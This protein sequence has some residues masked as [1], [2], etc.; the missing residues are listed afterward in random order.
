RAVGGSSRLG[1]PAHRPAGRARALRLLREA[2]RERRGT[3]PMS[4]TSALDVAVRVAQEAGAR[5]LQTFRDLDP[6]DA[7]EKSKTDVVSTADRASEAL[8]RKLLLS[9]FPGD[10]FLGEESGMC[11]PDETAPTWLVDPLD[12]TANFVRGFPHWAVS[13]ARTRGGVGGAL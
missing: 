8:C 10:S 3:R 9:A 7:T 6:E 13:I 5:L 1:V 2:Q 12:G 11:G 4:R